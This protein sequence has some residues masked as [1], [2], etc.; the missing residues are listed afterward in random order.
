MSW[1]V[2]SCPAV[3][4]C[5]LPLIRL[6]ALG[7]PGLLG[8][9]LEL[10]GGTGLED[11]RYALT[12]KFGAVNPNTPVFTVTLWLAVPGTG[13]LTVPTAVEPNQV[14]YVAGLRA[15]L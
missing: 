6:S 15:K 3:A 8:G 4:L 1:E 7:G 2:K 11:P 12:L 10:L 9:G 5:P 13:S 14:M